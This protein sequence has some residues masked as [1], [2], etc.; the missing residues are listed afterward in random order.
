M[1]LYFIWHTSGHHC[2]TSNT[3]KN[4]N[5]LGLVLCSCQPNLVL[6]QCTVQLSILIASSFFFVLWDENSWQLW[7]VLGV[8]PQK[9]VSPTRKKVVAAV[10]VEA[11]TIF[12]LESRGHYFQRPQKNA[13][14]VLC[15]KLRTFYR[16]FSDL[17]SF[18][19][20]HF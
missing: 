8:P 13:Q 16:T 14:S 18:K 9:K 7:R 15:M 11:V 5:K 19:I 10:F 1:F 2:K 20:A 12:V 6:V 3:L 17:R 4:K